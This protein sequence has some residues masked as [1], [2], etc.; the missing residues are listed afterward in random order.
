LTRLQ[1]AGLKVNANK[2]WFAQEELEYLV[3]WITRNGISDPTKKKE[4]CCFIGMVNYY[5]D[6][7]IRQSEVLAPL[8]ALTSNATPWKWTDE[9]QR[10]F[11][12]M[13]R[14]VSRETL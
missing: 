10:S 12:L 13:K 2:S 7:W 1:Q 5:R 3:Y 4:Q 9:H 14:I 8:A 11:D 6:M